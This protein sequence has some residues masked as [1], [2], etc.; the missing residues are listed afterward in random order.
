MESIRKFALFI[1]TGSHF[2]CVVCA[3]IY[4]YIFKNIYIFTYIYLIFTG[5]FLRKHPE[6]EYSNYKLQKSIE[7]TLYVN[8]MQDLQKA[9]ILVPSLCSVTVGAFWVLDKISMNQ[10]MKSDSER[11][12]LSSTLRLFRKWRED[13][14][15]VNQPTCRQESSRFSLH[16]PAIPRAK[17]KK[18]AERAW[19]SLLF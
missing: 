17:E 6:Q 1:Y 8:K 15:L 13:S 2:K 19:D 5:I 4:T 14:F 11:V 16:Y 18:D 10:Q 12:K 3:C 9:G 7:Q